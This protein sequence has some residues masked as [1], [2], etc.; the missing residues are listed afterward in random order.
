MYTLHERAPLLAHLECFA[1][2]CREEHVT[3][4]SR[5]ISLPLFVKAMYDNL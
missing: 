5:S 2:L 1:H 3:S 4:F